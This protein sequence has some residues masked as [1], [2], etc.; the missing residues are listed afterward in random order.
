VERWRGKGMQANAIN[1]T[2]QREKPKS[3]N[4]NTCKQEQIVDPNTAKQNETKRNL[5]RDEQQLYKLKKNANGVV[6]PNHL[7][8]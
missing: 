8:A 4:T 7:V 6:L 1:T 5:K 2:E 3:M